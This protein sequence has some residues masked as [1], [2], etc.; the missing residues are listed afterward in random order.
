M[1]DTY[2]CTMYV[3]LG[4]ADGLLGGSANSTADTLRP[5]MQ[6]IK[7]RL[8]HTIV[9]SCFLM[10][11][12]DEHY[13]FADCS[14]N[15]NPDTDEL[16]EIALQA[17]ETAKTFQLEPR[18]ALLSYST[19]GSGSGTDVDK[20]R[21]AAQR[22]QRMPLDYA[23]DGELQVDCALSARVAKLKAVDSIVGGNANI[24]IF[25]DLNAGNI[26]YKLVANLGGF[27]ALGP[28]LQG[29]R[30]PMN[31]LSRSATTEEIYKMAIITA[32]Q[33]EAEAGRNVN[34]DSS[35]LGI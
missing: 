6:L 22:L 34:A 27:E 18:V 28:I 35:N 33:K 24:L 29:V 9:S 30:L 3:E 31:D 17:A 5:I 32:M 26:G 14:L 19:H 25:P 2:F 1:K 13:I 20:V 15:R 4:Y 23:V 21:E 7:T 10:S 12:K 8:P 11:R 16:V